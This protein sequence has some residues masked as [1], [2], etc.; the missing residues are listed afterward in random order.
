[1]H[2]LIMLLIT[3]I[4]LSTQANTLYIQASSAN[5]RQVPDKDAPIV[6]KLGIGDAVEKLTD[7]NGWY[8][9][10]YAAQGIK[11]WIRS[12]L[13]GFYRPAL[14][15]ILR[16]Y[17]YSKGK[18]KLI[19]IE[20]AA[21]LRPFDLSIL[22]QLKQEMDNQG[23]DTADLSRSMEGIEKTQFAIT[24]IFGDSKKMI[25]ESDSLVISWYI[26]CLW[27]YVGLPMLAKYPCCQWNRFWKCQQY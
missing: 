19:W 14:Q 10:T 26:W 16:K 13:V 23:I 22:S 3:L 27:L 11:G 12:D 15:H 9:I 21:A 5:I 17:K 24:D 8:Q 2:R 7:A 25:F 6:G 4:S 1:M 18:K 20:R